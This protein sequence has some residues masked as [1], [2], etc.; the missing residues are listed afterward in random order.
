MQPTEKR[1]I[2]FYSFL[3]LAFLAVIGAAFAVRAARRSRAAQ[4]SGDV[5]AV[6]QA[7]SVSSASM[8]A[9][10]SS[11]PASSAPPAPAS[12]KHGLPVLMYHDIMTPAQKGDV[13]NGLVITTD[14]FDRQMAILR[15]AGFETVDLSE[16]AAYAAGKAD[17]VNRVAITFD[18]GYRTCGCLAVSILRKYGYRATVFDIT[19]YLD[20]P[21][22]P[23]NT[24]SFYPFQYF[25]TGDLTAYADTLDFAS[26]TDHMHDD[27]KGQPML[28]SRPA[29]DILD[30]LRLSRQ[31]LG[32]TLYLAYPFGKYSEQT[33]ELVRQAGFAAAFTTRSGF[34]QPGDDLY[35]LPRI[36]IN[37]PM[38]DSEFK[39]LLGIPG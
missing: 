3:A 6:S 17:F 13:K 1:R 27:Y 15:Q 12:T 28:I 22:E 5:S 39:R 4:G 37:S 36:E 21:D 29:A 33:I 25:N 14:E 20:L 23:V 2:F 8:P 16:V 9:A 10:V 34:V 18:D 30:D 31:K 7:V 35:R 32:G 19:K 11:T 24:Q 38:T 26:H